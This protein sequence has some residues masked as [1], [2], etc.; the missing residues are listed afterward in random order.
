MGGCC[1]TKAVL[2]TENNNHHETKERRR[3]I[4][5]RM[6]SKHVKKSQHDAMMIAYS[7]IESNGEDKSSTANILKLKP[8]L[9]V[10]SLL[11]KIWDYLEFDDLERLAPWWKL[12]WYVVTLDRL[13]E[14]Y[15]HSYM[16][17]KKAINYKQEFLDSE[18]GWEITFE[19]QDTRKE[20][21]DKKFEIVNIQTMGS[22]K[23]GRIST[24]PVRVNQVKT[25]PI[26]PKSLIESKKQISDS[27][28]SSAQPKKSKAESGSSITWNSPWTMNSKKQSIYEKS[29]I[30]GKK[31][32]NRQKT[33]MQQVM[34][35][36]NVINAQKDWPKDSFMNTV[37]FSDGMG[38]VYSDSDHLN[39]ALL[40]INSDEIDIKEV[41]GKMNKLFNR[42]P[43]IDE[44]RNSP[45]IPLDQWFMSKLVSSKNLY[46]INLI[47]LNSSIN[48][49]IINLY[50]YLPIIYSKIQFLL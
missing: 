45:S 32:L 3:I 36:K 25:E 35:M 27:M 22:A 50:L 12:F 41:D 1:G 43:T 47:F 14:K 11:D 9:G 34:Y 42:Q 4:K 6:S 7:Y 49:N 15:D 10:L 44:R 48:V 29:P 37:A 16:S 30:I 39:K 5:A 17:S 26:K 8:N 40:S 24:D 46:I 20:L 21:S 13:L 18:S 2:I 23:K 19:N 31:I 33:I 38:E 28:L